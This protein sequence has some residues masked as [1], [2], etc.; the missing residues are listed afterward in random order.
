[1]GILTPP[2]KS[3]TPAYI[4]QMCEHQASETV[5][6]NDLE[7]YETSREELIRHITQIVLRNVA[8]GRV[9]RVI[10]AGQFTESRKA[11]SE[12]YIDRVIASY[13]R[14]HGRVEALAARDEV[15]WTELF[16]QLASRA[17]NILLRM[18]APSGRAQDEAA[19]FAQ[20]VCETIFNHPFPYDVSFDAWVTRILKN[21]IL[22]CYTRSP[23]L[24]DRKPW[25]WSL[26]RPSRS[27]PDDDFSLYD[28]LS[29]ESS[30][31][32]FEKSEVQ[33]MLIQA[34]NRLR[35]TA[36][37]QV[38]VDT[39]F[40]DLS[41]DEIAMRLGKTKQAVYNLRFRAL[42]NLRRILKK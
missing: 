32:P 4:L 38:V 15:A 21:R 27:G 40:Y 1:M 23:D 29:D 22:W 13:L 8:S 39:F 17:Y 5:T 14:E 31:A 19:D 7:Q 25:M 36:Q 10:I 28:L 26:D 12:A 6:E 16:Q 42:R 20:D 41:D 2:T 33:E 3:V 35:S 18:Q 30:D 24:A 37:Q 9:Q 34:I 11:L